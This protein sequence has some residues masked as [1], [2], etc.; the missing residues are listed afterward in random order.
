MLE[1]VGL[2]MCIGGSLSGRE[3]GVH[4]CDMGD[5]V[6]NVMSLWY[7]CVWTHFVISINVAP[8]PPPPPPFCRCPSAVGRQWFSAACGGPVCCNEPRDYPSCGRLATDSFNATQAAVCTCEIVARPCCLGIPPR[9]AIR[10]VSD[11]EFL[12]GWS[13][14]ILSHAR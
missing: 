10:T 8:P 2:W 14:F 6:A 13:F 3:V 12:G 5:F 9:C 7:K 11:C 1:Y 4:R